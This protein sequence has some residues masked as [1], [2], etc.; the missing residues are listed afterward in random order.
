M[1]SL[2]SSCGLSC[3]RDRRSK[4]IYNHSKSLGLGEENMKSI[5]L[6]V[7]AF[8]PIQY[9]DR[10]W[11]I[12]YRL[13]LG[14]GIEAEVIFLDKIGLNPVRVADFNTTLDFKDVI[15]LNYPH[16]FLTNLSPLKQHILLGRINPGIL[17]EVLKYDVLLLHGV[18]HI[19]YQLAFFLA[20]LLGKKVTIRG[21]GTPG[22]AR[23]KLVKYLKKIY[24]KYMDLVFYSCSGNKRYFKDDF[25][26]PDDKLRFLPCAVDNNYFRTKYLEL[27]EK[28]DTL[29][30][31]LGI[32]NNDVV[33]LFV[34]RFVD[35]KRPM[36]ILKAI[37]L[38]IHEKKLQN[39]KALF[40]GGG[41]LEKEMT[42]FVKSK[43][44]SKNVIIK[45]FVKHSEIVEYYTLADIF[46]LPSSMD[47]SP[48]VLN[49][50]M[51]FELP[52]ITTN[53][54]GTAELVKEGYNGFKIAVGDI[55]A[56]ADRISILASDSNLRRTFGKNSWTMVK[57]WNFERDAK[58]ILDG[59]RELC[60]S[61]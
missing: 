46:V 48:K 56:L 6:G 12:L 41:P 33:I 55:R 47:P 20:K 31:N 36:D 5:R 14:S 35:I 51:N 38:L 7:I 28:R 57:D 44:L 9:Q 27:L 10:L 8:H 29:R 3:G 37:D 49:E 11:E 52:V 40:I 32:G 24:F 22:K 42:T 30:K 2:R 1:R 19:S 18:N 25:S 13:S 26:V 54:I 43:G 60:L 21:E 34:G 50:A 23:N 39:L 53:V 15:R 4:R 61:K 59:V 45:G 17:R 16:K 58:A